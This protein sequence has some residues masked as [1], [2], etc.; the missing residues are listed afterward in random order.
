[1]A[2][3]QGSTTVQVKELAAEEGE[4]M[5]LCVVPMEMQETR[6]I[7]YVK[8]RQFQCVSSEYVGEREGNEA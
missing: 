3:T 6:L 2:V 5:R 1:M 8:E 4:G 7:R